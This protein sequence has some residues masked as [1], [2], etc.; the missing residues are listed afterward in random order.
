VPHWLTATLAVLTPLAAW[1]WVVRPMRRFARDAL[2][3]LRQIRASASGVQSL[4]QEVRGLAGS[5]VTLAAAMLND[6][7]SLRSEHAEL[8]EHHRELAQLVIDLDADVRRI[9]K[10]VEHFHPQ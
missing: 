5:I 7:Q 10:R 1:R 8:R 3:L 4:T 9:A 6:Q 2:T